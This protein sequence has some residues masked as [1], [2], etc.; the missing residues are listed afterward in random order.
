MCEPLTPMG[1][2]PLRIRL[3]NAIRY[4]FRVRPRVLVY[5]HVTPE[6]FRNLVETCRRMNVR[7]ERPS[8]KLRRLVMAMANGYY[9]VG[10]G[11]GGGG[12]GDGGGGDGSA[13]GA[14]GGEGSSGAGTG[15]EGNAGAGTAG[16]AADSAAAATGTSGAA[17]VGGGTAA[18][19]AAAAAAG[20]SA[21]DADEGD[22]SDEAEPE[23]SR[24]GLPAPADARAAAI[25]AMQA[26]RK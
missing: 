17:D 2:P 10:V 26:A 12:G 23:S 13:G 24:P 16:T 22:P 11:D 5:D 25:S 18:A 15:G 21:S 9:C 6:A 7:G 19:A 4:F 8:R 1:L 20:M 3:E 14:A